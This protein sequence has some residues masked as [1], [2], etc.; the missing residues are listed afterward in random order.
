MLL[1]FLRL[2]WALFVGREVVEADQIDV[3]ALA[4]FGDFEKIEDA[5]ET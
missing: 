3:V 4:V 5:Q 1:H 2:G